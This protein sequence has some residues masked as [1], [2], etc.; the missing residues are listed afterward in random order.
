MQA[1]AHSVS[2]H[3]VPRSGRGLCWLPPRAWSQAHS[4]RCVQR[5]GPRCTRERRPRAPHGGH[6][7]HRAAPRPS[8]ASSVVLRASPWDG[9][10]P[11]GPITVYHPSGRSSGSRDGLLTKQHPR[12]TPWTCYVDGAGQEGTAPSG[13]QRA[14]GPFLDPQG[15]LHLGPPLLFHLDGPQLPHLR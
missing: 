3:P 9:T 5:R 2:L 12:G 10:Q 7:D 4:R 15:P 6:T 8:L 13:A 11:S 1:Q 14:Q